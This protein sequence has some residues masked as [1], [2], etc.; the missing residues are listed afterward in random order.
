MKDFSLFEEFKNNII[1][2][3]FSDVTAVD[4][5][6]QTYEGF[7]YEMFDR[8]SDMEKLKLAFDTM[9]LLIKEKNLSNN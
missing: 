5:I 3:G 7:L 8:Y 9:V 6:L 1:N 2:I 4:V